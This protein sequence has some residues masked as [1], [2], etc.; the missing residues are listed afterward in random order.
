MLVLPAAYVLWK[1]ARG[2]T[3]M[4]DEFRKKGMLEAYDALLQSDPI[5]TKVS[6]AAFIG[7]L[8]DVVSA[9]L[10]GLKAD[11]GSATRQAIV[12]G[13][14]ITPLVHYWFAF[15][16]QVFAGWSNN[17]ITAICK[18]LVQLTVAEPILNISWMSSNGLL[19]GEDGETILRTIRDNFWNNWNPST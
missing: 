18:T 4:S 16:E 9:K 11:P 10:S 8:A 3:I 5:R 15:L 1:L 17:L 2:E 6:T 14:V 12:Q 19:A 13:A 7:A